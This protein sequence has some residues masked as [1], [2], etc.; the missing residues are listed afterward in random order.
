MVRERL[1]LN[2]F[3]G[4]RVTLRP[5]MDRDEPAGRGIP[6]GHLFQV[7]SITLSRSHYTLITGNTRTIVVDMATSD[8]GS[9]NF[10]HRRAQRPFR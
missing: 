2:V 8:C 4:L 10:G 6:G 1:V 5:P 3:A 7:S 9:V